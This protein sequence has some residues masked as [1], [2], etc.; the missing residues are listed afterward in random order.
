M[1]LEIYK[2]GSVYWFKGGSRSS[3]AAST[4]E[5]A[6]A[7][8][9]KLARGAV[10]REFQNRELGRHYGGDQ[11]A[12]TFA[13]AITRYNAGPEMARDL[14]KVL[15]HLGPLDLHRITPRMVRELGRVIYPNGSTDSW[16]RH[17]V[18]P[19]RAV[20]NNA[21]ELGLGPPIKIKAYTAFERE[22]Q[23]RL[24][25]R[26]S[27]REK[28]PGS[29]PWL[30]RFR[31]VAPDHLGALAWFMFETAAR[32]GQATSIRFED[33]DPKAGVV[34]MP[35][36]KGFPPQ[37]V[38][39]SDELADAMSG[40]KPRYTRRQDGRKVKSDRLFGYLR[41]DGVYK[42]W[43]RVCRDAGIE[44]IMPHAAGRHGFGTEMLVRRGLDAATVSKAGRWSDRST[45][46]NRYVHS[47]NVDAK[48]QAAIRTGREQAEA[49]KSRNNLT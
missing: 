4:T 3:Q 47:E 18:T 10:L 33:F 44:V 16:R 31:E 22:R 12:I 9:L 35:A 37:E 15:D 43:K 2:R 20:V 49:E 32:I 41:K 46:I 21:H 30:L 45:L 5:K 28:V 7:S 1:P 34:Q 40:L 14:L 19:I 36:A 8:L 26:Q 42:T 11:T 39:L 25:G 6:R 17:V 13:E 48:I 24:R 23:D 29:W 38:M 27:R